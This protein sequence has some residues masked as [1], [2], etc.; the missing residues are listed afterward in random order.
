L[1]HWD[2]ELQKQKMGLGFAQILDWEIGLGQNL[3]WKMEFIH[4]N[5]GPSSSKVLEQ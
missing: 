5:L 3:G 2:W 1:G 4:P